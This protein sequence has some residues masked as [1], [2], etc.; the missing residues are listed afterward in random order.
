MSSNGAF[1]TQR[2][3]HGPPALHPSLR[4]RLQS[5]MFRRTIKREVSNERCSLRHKV[6]PLRLVRLLVAVACAVM[7]YQTPPTRIAW[8]R[9]V[10][11]GKSSARPSLNSPTKGA[12]RGAVLLL[13]GPR[14]NSIVALFK[15]CKLHFR[16]NAPVMAQGF[17][18]K[19]QRSGD[20]ADPVSTKTRFIVLPFND[21]QIGV[22]F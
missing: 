3:T 19:N 17:S 13:G 8:S 14:A 4:R 11:C 16:W 9:K 6:C 10:S 12:E 20:T 5:P 21:G 1:Q 2:R 15:E 18:K 7:S 22:V